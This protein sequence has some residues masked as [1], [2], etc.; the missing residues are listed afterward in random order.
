MIT[1]TFT[2]EEKLNKDMHIQRTVRTSPSLTNAEI[3]HANAIAELIETWGIK[4]SKEHNGT[5]SIFE[6]DGD[7]E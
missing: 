6:M 5:A 1:L 2:I 4:L 7:G 3:H